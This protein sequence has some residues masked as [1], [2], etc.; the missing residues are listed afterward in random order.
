M[1]DASI[2]ECFHLEW[3]GHGPEFTKS[4]IS[5][6]M[7]PEGVEWICKAQAAEEILLACTCVCFEN[8]ALKYTMKYTKK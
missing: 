2:G 8:A 6:A 4:G 1:Y 3:S 5:K 7:Q